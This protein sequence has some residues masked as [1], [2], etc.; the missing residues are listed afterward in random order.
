MNMATNMDV[1]GGSG[2]HRSREIVQ[3]I[4]RESVV[5]ILS[6][7]KNNLWTF[8]WQDL[9]VHGLVWKG[10]PLDAVGPLF[11]AFLRGVESL[12]CQKYC[13]KWHLFRSRFFL[14]LTFFWQERRQYS[15]FLEKLWRCTKR[16]TWSHTWFRLALNLMSTALNKRASSRD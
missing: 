6:L 4:W 9:L 13:V 12:S 7:L 8:S 1:G 5:K 16:I 11:R 14:Q 2:C 15:I 10:Q 3:Q